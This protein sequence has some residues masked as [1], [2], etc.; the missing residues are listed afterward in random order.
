MDGAELDKAERG[1]RFLPS[2]DTALTVE[3][4]ERVDRS[5]SAAVIDLAA[6]IDSADLAGIVEIVPTFRSLLVHYDP[7]LTTADALEGQI[8]GLLAHP[9]AARQSG[10]RWRIP[11]CYEA[12]FAPDLDEVARRTGLSPAQVVE[13]HTAESYHVYML[14]FLPGYPYMGDLPD[15]IQLPR[16]ESPRIRVPAGSVAIA[17]SLTAVYTIEGPAGWHLIGRTPVPFFD[18]RGAPPALLSPGD[19]VSFEA[20]SRDAY[21][22]LAAEVANGGFDA[23]SLRAA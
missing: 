3:L 18:L 7:L 23:A 20:T 9:T 17:T 5:L 22:R 14:G 6:R 19:T 21:D 4:G 12:D 8:T 2:G 1:A 10:R 15:A 13:Q 16:R 11:A